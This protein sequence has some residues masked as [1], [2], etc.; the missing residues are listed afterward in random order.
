VLL[1]TRLAA[2]E[3]RG[4]NEGGITGVGPRERTRGGRGVWNQSKVKQV[5]VAGKGGNWTW[6]EGLEAVILKREKE[7]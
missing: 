6:K 5:G 4:L 1:S 3:K 2:V 7:G